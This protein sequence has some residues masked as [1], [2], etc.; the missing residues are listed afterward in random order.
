M[1]FFGTKNDKFNF[2]KG[3]VGFGEYV[4]DN[5]F[6]DEID[7]EPA[8]VEAPQPPVFNNPQPLSLK[9]VAPKS[10]DDAAEITNYL[11][12]G[13]TVLLN[14]DGVDRALMVRI[15]DYLKGASQVLGGALT[16]AG[17][18]TIVVAPKNVDISSIEAMVKTND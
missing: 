4:D 18:A 2:G 15:I 17:N 14:M 1:G 11:M 8:A 9:I 7:E 12:N 5:G 3:N 16:K 10:Y 13:N 6:E